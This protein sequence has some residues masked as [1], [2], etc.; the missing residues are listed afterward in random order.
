[1]DD[2]T[3]S[4]LRDLEEEATEAKV[5]TEEACNKM[6]RDLHTNNPQLMAAEVKKLN[7]VNLTMFFG[8]SS[9]ESKSW[10]KYHHQLE[11]RLLKQISSEVGKFLNCPVE[12]SELKK[13][14]VDSRNKNNELNGIVHG[15]KREI[16]KVRQIC[17]DF[18]V[19]T[20]TEIRDMFIRV[21]IERAR[22]IGQ[23]V[24]PDIRITLLF[25]TSS[26]TNVLIY[27]AEADVVKAD[28]IYRLPSVTLDT[29]VVL[30]MKK[31]KIVDPLELRKKCPVDLAVTHRIREDLKPLLSDEQFLTDNYI[32]KIPSI[33]RCCFDSRS[34]RFLL[35]PEFD[36]PGSTEFLKMAESIIDDFKQTGENPP[37][38]QDWD[39]LHAHY[40]SGRDFF[41]TEDKKILKINCQLKE[42]GIRVMRFE[43]FLRLIEKNGILLYPKNPENPKIQSIQI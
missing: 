35:N 41:L 7:D 37:E 6:L 26:T 34:E 16:D 18:Q 32:R 19:R 9:A 4:L 39:H 12:A 31:G 22:H 3:T 11:A 10:K 25:P 14:L 24:L 15:P 23:P 30:Y 36:K 20:M 43:E 29:N 5:E 33:M 2:L 1:M 17:D 38:Y 42:L 27:H 13:Y 40:M 8:N 21:T 28:C